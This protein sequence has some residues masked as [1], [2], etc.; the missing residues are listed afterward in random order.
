MFVPAFSPRD[1]RDARHGHRRRVR[2]EPA[3]RPQPLEGLL[4]G[5][6][7]SSTD[8]AAIFAV[9]R[10]STL[11]RRLARTLEGEAGMNDPVAVLLVLGLHRVDRAAGL[12]RAGHARGDRRGARHRRR[13]RPGRRL[14]GRPAAA[15]R[16][17]RVGR[18]VPGRVARVR[19]ARLRRGGRPARLGLPRRVPHRPGHRQLGHARPA[20]DHDVPRRARMGRAARDVPR[21]RPARVPVGLRRRLARGDRPRARPRVRRTADR[22]L[23]ARRSAWASRFRERVALGVG[24]PAR[25]GARGP[26]DVPRHRGARRDA[27]VLRHRL[28][29]RAGLDAA[30]GHDVRVALGAARRHDERGGHPDAVHGPDDRAPAGC[31]DRRVPGRRRATPSP[32]ASC[33]SSACRAR[34]CST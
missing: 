22:D 11:R 8:G 18:P 7:V 24:G 2:G 9:L 23:R 26:R 16:A 6:I 27:G 21:P 33:A 5:A 31:G 20:D 29:R 30:A 4:L 15:R 14:A 1:R 25:R 19:R 28:L 34:R 13:R 12:R 17:P 32:G 3:V 10:G